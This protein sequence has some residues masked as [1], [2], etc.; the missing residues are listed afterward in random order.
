MNGIP[1]VFSA[2]EMD[3]LEIL[4]RRSGRVVPKK[5]VE[6]HIY[7]LG[8]DVASNAIEVYV[9]RLRKTLADHGAAVTIHT[10]RGVGYLIDQANPA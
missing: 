2:R 5:L 1:Q 3:V 4:M 6:D 9:H 10:V 8:G 7:G